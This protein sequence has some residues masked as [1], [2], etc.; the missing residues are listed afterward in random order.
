MGRHG[1]QRNIE[2]GEGE[3]EKIRGRES[4]DI[5]GRKANGKEGE[6]MVE[7]IRAV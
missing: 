6:G 5:A 4:G 1:R 3:M 2:K 7:E